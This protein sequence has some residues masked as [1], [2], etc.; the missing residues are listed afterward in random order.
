MKIELNNLNL[1]NEFKVK[2]VKKAQSM[3]GMLEK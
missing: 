3:S 1:M 2:V